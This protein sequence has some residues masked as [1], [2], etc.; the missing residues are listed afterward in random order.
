MTPT[1]T[2]P[3]SRVST[4]AVA[5]LLAGATASHAAPPERMRG[6]G[7]L[8]VGNGIVEKTFSY[9][10]AA[11]RFLPLRFRGPGTRHD[12]SEPR[13]AEFAIRLS[14]TGADADAITLDGSSGW[15]LADTTAGTAKDGGGNLD[16][17]LDSRV[18]P[19]RVTLRYR[20]HPATAAIRTWL[21]VR[22]TGAKPLTLLA[23]DA[24]VFG[25]PARGAPWSLTGVRNFTWTRPD[26][27]FSVEE[28]RLE[29]GAAGRRVTGAYGE[30][31]A[32]FVLR[33]GAFDSGLFGGWEFGGT[34]SL[35]W[36]ADVDGRAAIRIG[37]DPETFRHVLAPNAAFAAPPGFVGVFSGDL[38]AASAATRNLVERRLSLPKPFPEF[39]P[40]GFDTWGY[41]DKPDE[42]TLHRLVDEAGAL[43]AELF[44]LD[45]Q[46][47]PRLG[48]WQ[49]D[50]ANLPSGVGALS[51]RVHARGMR[52]GLWIALG[53]A[54]PGARVLREHPD[55]AARVGGAPVVGDFGGWAL[56]LADRRVRAWVLSEVD[57]L[58]DAWNVDWLLHD[59]H[60]VTRC[61]DERHGHQAG[62]GDWASAA[63]YESLL[64]EIHKR[65]PGLVLES[66]WDGGPLLDFS[67]TR[68]HH[69][70][71]LN[72]ENDAAG[73]RRAL[74]GASLFLPPRYL[75]KYV[76][77]DDAAPADVR[78]LSGVGGGPFLLMGRPTGWDDATRAAARAAF[79]LFKALRTRA[80]GAVLYRPTEIP[81]A[82]AWDALLSYDAS[83]GTGALLVFRAAGADA[84]ASFRLP[85]LETNATFDLRIEDDLPDGT[86]EFLP[87][88]DGATLRSDGIL[89]SLPP[90][91][92]AGVVHLDRVGN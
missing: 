70:T 53:S 76:G 39:P 92:A 11:G 8:V 47:M 73:N 14:P 5:L 75:G 30:W 22:N 19:V 74:H 52:F 7:P 49:S 46:W 37:V 56:C 60:V 71:N 36:E 90:E 15:D 65:H 26:R 17:V 23:A 66:C 61:D 48:D 55:W 82:V 44:T 20:A 58:V 80:P 81:G 54:D 62:D 77:D 3:S 16:V 32:W 31:A 2:A 24:P 33:S 69:A 51:E 45:A 68:R 13:P 43:G 21:T 25:L 84:S 64:D 88:L 12:L 41:G 10:A 59:F 78:F 91:R 85:G 86:R 4:G 89:V 18:L 50:P 72:D 40:A 35:R 63:G 27:A 28:A 87:R 1:T 57:R 83:R 34:G 38:D 42:A 29:P 9:E 67:M 79:D 6:S